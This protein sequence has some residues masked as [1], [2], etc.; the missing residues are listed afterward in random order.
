MVAVPYPLGGPEGDAVDRFLAEAGWGIRSGGATVMTAIPGVV[1]GRADTIGVTVRVD[2]EPD[3]AWLGMY[4]YRGTSVPV[5][6]R[7]ILMSAPWQ[8][9]GVVRKDRQVIAIGRVAVADGWAGLTA[10][11]VHPRHRRRKL[12]T[13]VTAAL[14]ACAAERGAA[15]LYL[16]M[17]DDNVAARALYHKLGFSDHH[18]YHYRVAPGGKPLIVDNHLQPRFPPGSGSGSERSRS[19]P[20][21]TF[22][23]VRCS[24]ECVAH[25]AGDSGQAVENPCDDVAPLRRLVRL[26]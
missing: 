7:Q 15:G 3:E 19:P 13:A 20:V 22:E 5:G 26:G 11:E 21:R 12:A 1:A 25:G 2:P 18:R 4:H 8:R 23:A 9:F 17:E 10:V 6:A 24:V 16:Q 14:A